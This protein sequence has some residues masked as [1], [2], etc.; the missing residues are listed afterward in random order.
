[1]KKKLLVV[2]SCLMLFLR[3]NAQEAK[4]DSIQK[5]VEVKP[6]FIGG[7]QAL[8]NY[9]KKNVK[10]PKKARKE[11]IQG[12]V[13]VSFVIEKDGAIGEVLIKK[14]VHELLDEEAMRVIK[15]MPKWTPGTQGGKPVRVQFVLPISFSLK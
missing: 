9:I 14:G 10:Y 2:F 11:E 8:F 5:I 4:Q 3:V 7:D 12:K 6:A 1:M 15:S 13:Y